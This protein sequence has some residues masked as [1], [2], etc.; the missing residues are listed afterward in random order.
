MSKQSGA[1]LKGASHPVPFY[2]DDFHGLRRCS[3]PSFRPACCRRG[4]GEDAVTLHCWPCVHN[5]Y[6]LLSRTPHSIAPRNALASH[7]YG[8]IMEEEEKEKS[9]RKSE[10][11]RAKQK[12]EYAAQMVRVFWGAVTLGVHPRA[13]HQSVGSSG[14]AAPVSWSRASPLSPGTPLGFLLRCSKSLYFTAALPSPAQPSQ[15]PPPP[16]SS[17][18]LS[19]EQQQQGER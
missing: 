3:T 8:P 1:F 11:V 19:T 10:R 16:P 15:P 13:E 9:E 17:Q 4:G 6:L 7:L 5:S 18:R 14:G 2:T 12:G